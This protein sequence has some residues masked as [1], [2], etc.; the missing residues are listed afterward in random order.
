MTALD[1][2]FAWLRSHVTTGE[3]HLVDTLGLSPT[4]VFH[5]R[6]SHEYVRD[7]YR[8]V[9]LWSSWRLALVG[10]LRRRLLEA[11][12][13]VAECESKF[14]TERLLRFQLR[15]MDGQGA[16]NVDLGPRDTVLDV[17]GW[18]TLRQAFRTAQAAP[19]WEVVRENLRIDLRAFL[20]SI[21]VQ[22]GELQLA[23]EPRSPKLEDALQRLAVL[24]YV[25][26]ALVRTDLLAAESHFRLGHA[27]DVSAAFRRAIEQIVKDAYQE[28]VKRTLIAAPVAV[29]D[30]ASQADHVGKALASRGAT[31]QAYGAYSLLSELGSHAG[32]VDAVELDAAWHAGVAGVLMLARRL[33]P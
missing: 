29:P 11:D 16:L 12:H 33:K 15:S 6:D 19:R 4:E 2:F 32:P 18:V 7:F 8:R 26:S 30:L 10:G 25:D 28:G 17:M 22:R 9:D 31:R 1:E 13:L 14:A 23:G 3:Q 24:Q 21:E 5:Q 27:K 20:A